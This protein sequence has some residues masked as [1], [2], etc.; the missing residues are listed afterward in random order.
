MPGAPKGEN[1]FR[2][3]PLKPLG[4]IRGK[5]RIDALFRS[6]RRI[7]GR[8]LALFFRD[9]ADGI[10]RCSVFVPRRLGGPAARNRARRALREYVRTHPHPALEGKETII[11]CKQSVDRESLNKARAEIGK[12]LDRMAGEQKNCSSGRPS[13]RSDGTNG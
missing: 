4:A 13:R 11:L 2:S 5:H 9:S 6:G 10:T 3:E 1:A 8:R 7:A 12:L